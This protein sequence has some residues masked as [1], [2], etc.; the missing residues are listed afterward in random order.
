MDWYQTFKLSNDKQFE[1]KFRDVI[2]LYLDPPEK[3][4]VLCCDGK[5]QCQAL[6][7][8]RSGLSSG[9]G[10]VRT[11]THDY[12]RQ[13]TVCLFAALSY[14]EGKL[15]YRTE[16]KR[17]HV[18]WLRFPLQINRE[19]PKGPDIRLIADN[20][21]AHKH[22]KVQKWLENH[23]RF[24]MH[25]TPASSSWMNLVERFFADRTADCVREGSS[26]S[27]RELADASAA[28]LEQR[29]ERPKPYR[30]KASGEEI[31]AKI[32]SARQAMETQ[33]N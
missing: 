8:T 1:G 3:S 17:A 32:N 19:V 28:Y 5:T 2:G 9:V 12:Y 18:E 14:L 24:H 11:R 4:V 7:R 26:T 29:N 20:Y 33:Q 16:S 15:I 30:C 25:F 6:E 10:R 27:A 21:C 22:A 31:P 13:C 23:K